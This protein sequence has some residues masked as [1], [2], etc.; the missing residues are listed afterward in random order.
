M[1]ASEAVERAA[2]AEATIAQ[3][4][5]GMAAGWLSAAELV[6]FHL[7]RIDRLNLRG[8]ELR[9]VLETN[10]QA[11][12]IA[13]QRDTERRRG[14]LRGP[15]HG[16]PVLVKD[17]LETAD[18]LRTT[19]GSTALLG[20]RPERDATVIAKLRAAGAIVLGKTNK[21]G[22][23]SGSAGWSPRGGQGRNPHR[24]DRSPHGSSSGSAAAVAAGLCAFALGTE[25][26]GSILGPAGVNGVV[27]L[28]P[29][30]GLTSRAGMIPG[31]PSLD[32]I[33]PL[34]RS[35]AD[36]AAVLGVLTGVDGRDP[37]T[38]AGT[39]RFRADY[40]ELL[41]QNALAGTRIG[42]PREAFFG[43]DD[44]ADA[45]AEDAIRV[46]A[47]AGATIV[48][49]TEIRSLPQ[50]MSD[51]SLMFAQLQEVKHHLDAY[52]AATPGEHPRSIAELIAYNREHADTEMPHFGQET[53]EMVDGLSGDLAD[54]DY[55]AALTTLRRLSRDEGIDAV[56][57][58]HR[59][60]A[61]VA[62]TGGP[63]WKVD[64]INGDPPARGSALVPGLAGY[65]AISVPAGAVRGLP[66]GVTFLA[67]AW[68]ESVLLR[69][70]YAFERTNPAWFPPAFE[71][72]SVG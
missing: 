30:V 14:E 63:A 20:A 52:L 31:V 72:P 68:G 34:C 51:E 50:I 17:N 48:D 33:G 56:L 12:E 44:H 59:L 32:T 11:A 42:V 25:T 67:G 40:R 23:I 27:G 26:I 62:P 18:R 5:A 43:Y 6:R 47:A 36:A 29:T 65:P 3:M 39:G 2:L 35:V 60:D 10:P 13:A 61:L 37:A 64:L 55:L 15:L 71:P 46:L 38:A 54:P 1:A 16:I 19:N 22:W 45:V 4:Q 58:E 7:D 70:G 66:I 8:P 69:I 53:L 21:S 57:R 24:L 9:A 49:R 28:K 41:E